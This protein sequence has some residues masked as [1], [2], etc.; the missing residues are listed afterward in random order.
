MKNKTAVPFPVMM[1]AG[2]LTIAVFAGII[3][4]ILLIKKAA[5]LISSGDPVSSYIDLIGV[6]FSVTFITTSLF[7]GLS[8]KSEKIY[9]LSYPEHYLIN[10]NLNFNVL[11]TTSFIC[12]AIEA[13]AAAAAGADEY[14]RESVFLSAFTVGILSI[15][16]LSYKFTAVFFSRQKLLNDAEA[17]FRKMVDDDNREELKNAVT[18]IFNNTLEAL[19]L[20]GSNM[21]R[22]NENV[23]LLLKY[24]D[25]ETCR[26]WLQKLIIEIGRNNLSMVIQLINLYENSEYREKFRGLIEEV[27]YIKKL[28]FDRDEI[29]NQLYMRR[30]RELKEKVA[31]SILDE[32]YTERWQEWHAVSEEVNSILRKIKTDNFDNCMFVLKQI[33]ELPYEFVKFECSAAVVPAWRDI[34]DK[35]ISCVKE[36]DA[37]S[38]QNIEKPLFAFLVDHPA[39]YYEYS[40][41]DD[42]IICVREQLTEQLN[43]MTADRIKELSDDQIAEMIEYI[44][45]DDAK[46]DL[47]IWMADQMTDQNLPEELWGI[48]K[49]DLYRNGGKDY[50]Y[51]VWGRCIIRESRRRDEA[52]SEVKK[53]ADSIEAHEYIDY[54]KRMTALLSH[55][56]KYEQYKHVNS[57]YYFLKEVLEKDYTGEAIISASPIVYDVLVK[58]ENDGLEVLYDVQNELEN[59]EDIPEEDGNDIEEAE[60]KEDTGDFDNEEK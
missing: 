5:P 26:Y 25:N 1:I 39:H 11:S 43:K 52:L 21:Q 10:S 32:E 28:P 50:Y 8:D 22:V 9:W 37:V 33:T 29:L 30:F 58:E 2:M 7:G 17:D 56:M 46:Q 23:T 53:D 57:L 20:E 16:I 51:H 47:F 3:Y 60:N 55:V 13:A 34:T 12:L 14:I 31:Y 19:D 45:D 4:A 49:K 48:Y 44:E 36:K 6:S 35:M 15:V 24:Y 18:G 42:G 54:I 59:G 41:L 40:E 27:A 38:F